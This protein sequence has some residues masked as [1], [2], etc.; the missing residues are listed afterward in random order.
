[1]IKPLQADSP[2]PSTK[3]I[4]ED[5][6]SLRIISPAY[7]SARS[8]LNTILQYLYHSYFFEKCKKDKIFETVMSISVCEMQHLRLLGKTIT[9][10]GAAPVYTQ[11]PP[12]LFSF[13]SSKYVSYSRSLK[14]MLED[15]IIG[16]KQ[17][18]SG[19]EKMLIRLKNE[20]VRA[21]I[22]RILEDE[23][24]HLSALENLRCELNR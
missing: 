19:Y 18:I 21:I 10:L 20:G 5:A 16:E 1:M 13:Y 15:D 17:A 2:Y 24:L 8:E 22:S 6:F 9:A 14:N 11:Y 4:T 23:R 7:A 3:D 12:D